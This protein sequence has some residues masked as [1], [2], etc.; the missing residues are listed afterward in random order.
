MDILDTAVMP[1]VDSP[2]PD[3][4]YAGLLTAILAEGLRDLGAELTAPPL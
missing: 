3:G 1:A 2:D 4:N